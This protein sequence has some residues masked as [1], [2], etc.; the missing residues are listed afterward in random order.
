MTTAFR[1]FRPVYGKAMILDFAFSVKYKN[2]TCG[3]R[4]IF[5]KI[6]NA[7]VILVIWNLNGALFYDNPAGNN[8]FKVNNGNTRTRCEICSKL[9]IK[10]PE[11]RHWGRSGVFIVNFE[12]ISHLVIVF[13][14]LTLSR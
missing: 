4:F 11:R 14:T 13:R 12:Y 5:T 6:L 1:I 10:T 7:L 9:K 2:L 8:L 3:M